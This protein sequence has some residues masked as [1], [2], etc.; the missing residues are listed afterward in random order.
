[1][2]QNQ[3]NNAKV[4]IVEMN[5]E[6]NLNELQVA[7]NKKGEKGQFKILKIFNAKIFD[8]NKYSVKLSNQDYVE[9]LK[10]NNFLFM[11][12]I[13]R[14]GGSYMCLYDIKYIIEKCSIKINPEKYKRHVLQDILNG[15]KEDPKDESSGL[16]YEKLNNNIIL[17]FNLENKDSIKA[18]NGEKQE[19]VEI[20]IEIYKQDGNGNFPDLSTPENFE[21]YVKIFNDTNNTNN[22][23][24]YINNTMTFN[25]KKQFL[26][27]TL[28][29]S[30]QISNCNYCNVG[31]TKPKFNNNNKNNMSNNYTIKTINT[32]NMSINNDNNNI[33]N[34]EINDTDFVEVYNDRFVSDEQNQNVISKE[35]KDNLYKEIQNLKENFYN[36]LNEMDKNIN[37]NKECLSYLKVS[38][39]DVEKIV[40]EK[41]KIK[42]F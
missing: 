1:M 2:L 14:G 22:N 29:N 15:L 4:E 16:F 20:S 35:E 25:D 24:N 12:L 17:T 3:Q 26:G 19:K 11:T 41:K 27:S 42:I 8:T 13:A 9:T 33:N 32:N 21:K 36:R 38:H 34:F 10:C 37:I 31:N 39:E 5:Q 23:N 6:T 30:Q 7:F 18:E 28:N 40:L